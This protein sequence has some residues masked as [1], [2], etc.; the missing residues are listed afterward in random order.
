MFPHNVPLPEP[1]TSAKLIGGALH[2]LHLCTRVSQVRKVPDADLGW[3]DMYKEHDGDSWFDWT[4]PMTILLI[5]ASVL[6]TF[7]LF[8]RIRLYR[9]H[10]SPDPVSSP[11]ATF[12]SSSL[13]FSPIP[14]PTTSARLWYAFSGFWRFL[15]NMDP[16]K[17]L[18]AN[19][20]G[21]NVKTVQQLEV[22]TPGDA[23]LY[24]GLFVV[25]SPAH[26]MLWMGV[27]SANWMLMLA[28]M[29]LMGAQLRVMTRS[30]EVLLKD[31]EIIFAEVMHEY[32]RGFVYPRVNPVRKDVAVM[33]HQSEVVNVWEGY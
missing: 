19:G 12:V 33:T 2:F 11:S 14:P 27:S 28:V 29:A 6:N 18:Y 31:K 8:S 32:N 15:L 30:Y 9:L 26:A 4:T 25:Y 1:K 3:E 21:E 13:D 20:N 23:E 22:W 24:M 5:A 10:H 17:S 16:P 7:C